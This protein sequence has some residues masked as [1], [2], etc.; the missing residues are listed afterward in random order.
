LE[1]ADADEGEGGAWSDAAKAKKWQENE[2]R[3][4]EPRGG[5]EGSVKAGGQ[6]LNEPEG[7]CPKK[8]D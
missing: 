5:D 8:G 3:E 4:T 6:V 7:K 1:C 2:E